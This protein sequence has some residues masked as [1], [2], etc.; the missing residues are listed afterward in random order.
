[1]RATVSGACA[2]LRHVAHRSFSHAPAMNKWVSS[3][4]SEPKESQRSFAKTNIYALKEGCITAKAQRAYAQEHKDIRFKGPST[5]GANKNPA[6]PPYMGPYGVP[7][8]GRV[9]L[10]KRPPV[11][12]ATSAVTLSLSLRLAAKTSLSVVS[13]RQVTHRSPTT[14]RTTRTFRAWSR[15][16]CVFRAVVF[17]RATARARSSCP[18]ALTHA[19]VC[20]PPV[21]RSTERE[22]A[23]ADQ[24]IHWPRYQVKRARQGE[25]SFQ[26]EKV[27]ECGISVEVLTRRSTNYPGTAWGRTFRSDIQPFPRTA[28]STPLASA[29]LKGRRKSDGC[30]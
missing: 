15:K 29:Q 18:V 1:M 11:H 2:H 16:G 21:L 14:R 10:R 3:T 6:K 5:T 17:G 24:G 7:T 28:C 23:E 20:P 30:P 9:L 26:D 25:G 13:L 12:L 27:S 22:Q 8:S 4:P 19:C